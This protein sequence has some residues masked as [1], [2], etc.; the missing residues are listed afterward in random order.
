[1]QFLTFTNL[2]ETLNP[3]LRGVNFDG[4]NAGY[5]FAFGP[6][7]DTLDTA[8]S[9]CDPNAPDRTLVSEAN[10]LLDMMNMGSQ[11]SSEH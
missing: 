6:Q 4:R 1:M 8:P 5:L 11:I 9:T 2:L 3:D 7:A 10:K